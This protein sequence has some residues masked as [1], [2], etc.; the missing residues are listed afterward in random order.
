MTTGLRA[1]SSGDGG[2][3]HFQD[4]LAALSASPRHP[5]AARSASLARRRPIHNNTTCW[6]R[7]PSLTYNTAAARTSS[8]PT[9]A[10]WQRASIFNI[11][12]H[13][14]PQPS[15]FINNFKETWT[16]LQLLLQDALA[17]VS[18]MPHGAEPAAAS[19]RA[20]LG[21]GRGRQ[22]SPA[23]G[24]TWSSRREPPFFLWVVSLVGG[25]GTRAV[26][27]RDVPQPN[28]QASFL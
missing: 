17:Y 12:L 11:L 5:F 23:Q 8:T 14:L 9:P 22:P 4:H 7:I 26:L 20:V 3:P 28:F 21:H 15:N 2:C 24:S 25:A 18:A 10:C 16:T 13:P 1:R 19:C 27:L 6:R